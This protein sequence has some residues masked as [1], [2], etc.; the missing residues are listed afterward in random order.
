MN[1]VDFFKQKRDVLSVHPFELK[2]FLSPSLRDY[3]L[4]LR[5]K[6][7]NSQIGLLIKDH[8]LASNDDIA[9]PAEPVAQPAPIVMKPEAEKLFNELNDTLG[10]V[11]HVGQWL[12][13]DQN[14]INSFADVTEDH[15]WI[16]TDPER[17]AEESPFKTTIAHGFLTLSLLSVLTDSVDPDNQKFPTAKMTVNVGLNQVRFPYPVKAGNRVRASTKIQ[18]VTPIKRGLEIVQELTVEIEGVRRPGC[19]AESVIRLH[20]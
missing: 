8:K 12:T 18:S 20:F 19:V 17:A 16:H 7:N 13:V 14:R 15:Q 11:I 3:W 2:D 4:E 6:A 1:V 5:N 9:A 10:E